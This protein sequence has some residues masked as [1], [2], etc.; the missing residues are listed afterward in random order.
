MEFEVGL[1]LDC[2][3]LH[4]ER[5]MAAYLELLPEVLVAS[6]QGVQVDPQ[7]LDERD[8]GEVGLPQEVH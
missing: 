4:Q 1:H 2:H 5:V 8:L 3:Q 7:A 6:Y